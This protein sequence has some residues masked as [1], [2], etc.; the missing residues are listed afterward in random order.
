VLTIKVDD[1]QENIDVPSFHRGGFVGFGTGG[2]YPVHFDDFRILKGNCMLKGALSYT[3]LNSLF[4]IWHV[5]LNPNFE[6]NEHN[7][8]C[9]RTPL[10][11]QVKLLKFSN[12][13]FFSAS[14]SPVY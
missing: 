13:P 4:I 7:L 12:F 2:F 3:T 10:I 14:P 8:I 11:S 9:D 1:I 6:F 5:N